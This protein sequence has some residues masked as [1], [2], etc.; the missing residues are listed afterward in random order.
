MRLP[1][2]VSV[3][4]ALL[5]FSLCYLWP[6]P[7]PATLTR[8][9]RVPQYLAARPD[10]SPPKLFERV[11]YRSVKPDTVTVTI[12]R[13]DTARVSRY[14]AARLTAPATDSSRT[15]PPPA[16]LALLPPFSGRYQQGRLELFATRS[17]G[18]GWSAVY[19]AND[20]LTWAAKDTSVEV[21]GR[22]RLPGAVRWTLRLAKCGALGYAA[23]QVSGDRVVGLAAGGGCAAAHLTPP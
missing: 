23:Q 22:R 17:D 18:T 8:V 9:V 21:Q 3:L 6:T 15:T 16:P 7:Q 13:F 12:E 1:W 2:Y 19:R 11:I 14:C 20:P 10:T 5:G 4:S